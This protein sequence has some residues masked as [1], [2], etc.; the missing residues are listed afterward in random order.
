MASSPIPA[1]PLVHW[2]PEATIL[3]EQSSYTIALKLPQGCAS[4]EILV[5]QFGRQG[6]DELRVTILNNG[7]ETC[8]SFPKNS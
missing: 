5:S 2:E 8:L 1:S 6:Y 4:D 7:A 3:I